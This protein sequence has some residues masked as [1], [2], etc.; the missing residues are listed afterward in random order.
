M[1][2]FVL[3]KLG[4]HWDTSYRVKIQSANATRIEMTN[5]QK[6]SIFTVVSQKHF[7]EALILIS[8][9]Y[10]VTTLYLRN[11]NQRWTIHEPFKI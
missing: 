2:L 5:G 6:C 10:H 9:M 1:P 3:P 7:A 4:M 11:L 8:F